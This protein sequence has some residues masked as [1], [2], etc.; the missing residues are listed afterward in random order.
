[1]KPDPEA[2]VLHATVTRL[3]MNRPPTLY[4]PAP[5]GVQLA[6]LRC[7]N[8]PLHYYRY[9]YDQVGRKWHWTAALMLTD[10][11]LSKR[12]ADNKTDI[13]VLYW[14]G[15]PCGFFELRL[16]KERECRL[17]HFGLMEHAIGRGLGRWFLGEA[18]RA[19]WAHNPRTITVETCTLD[20]PAALGL[21]Q[22]MGFDPVWRKEEVVRDLSAEERAAILFPRRLAS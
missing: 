20:H 15:S 6:L 18:I 5:Y 2:R 14:D 12:L 11:E 3:R 4:P 8:M 22:K 16:L 1:M 9:L 7:R 10:A 19:A 13:H 17:V 21:Y